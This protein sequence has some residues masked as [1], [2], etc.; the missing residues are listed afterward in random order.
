MYSKEACEI[1]ATSFAYPPQLINT[2]TGS[3][4]WSE[5]YDRHI[6]DVLK[7]QVAIAAAV[8]REM[9]LTI[10]SGSLDSR[11]ALKSAEAYDLLLRAR[12]SADRWDKDG[13]DEA[14]S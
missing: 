7:L 9:Q 6:G 11:A 2:K 12:H 10:A 1:P 5:T 13:L 14:V 4:G 3:H 8:V